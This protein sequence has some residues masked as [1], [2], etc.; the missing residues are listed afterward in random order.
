MSDKVRLIA[1]QANNLFDFIPIN[2]KEIC[3]SIEGVCVTY[4]KQINYIYNQL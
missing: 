3:F 1:V 4:V 2:N